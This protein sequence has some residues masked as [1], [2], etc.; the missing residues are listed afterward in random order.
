MIKKTIIYGCEE[1]GDY[2]EPYLTR[3]T[4]LERKSFQIC[5]HVFHR[6]DADDQHD[7]PWNF[8]SLILWRGY[9]EVTGDKR[10]RKYP[11]ML[12]F[13][14][15]M[16]QHRELINNRK[17]ITLVIMGKRLREWSFFTKDGRIG[18]RRYFI[19]NGC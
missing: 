19:Q 7:H 1:R 12:L 15:A 17:A 11:G 14:K 8:V 18:W 6:S 2:N 5:L 3:Y 16:H 9:V 13:R 4:L 10:R